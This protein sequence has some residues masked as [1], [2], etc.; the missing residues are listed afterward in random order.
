MPAPRTD[1]RSE[2]VSRVRVL[3]HE[4]RHDEA[5]RA[6]EGLPAKLRTD[7]ELLFLHALILERGER[8]ADAVPVAR[9]SLRAREH[10][11]TLLLLARC[12]RELGETEACLG[13]LDRVEAIRPGLESAAIVRG[14]ALE[15]AGR[16]DE[17]AAVLGPLVESYAGTGKRPPLALAVAWSRTLVQLKRFDE[18]IELIDEILSGRDLH[19]RVRALQL[20]LKA[21]AFDR[22]GN[23]EGAIAAATEANEIDRIDFQ[24]DLYTA[25]VDA[26]IANWSRESMATFP[27]SR[28]DSAVPVFIAGMPRS[29]TS[30]ID[31]I[32]DAHPRASG[33]GELDTIERFAVRL[34]AAY[35][36]ARP[37]G[38]RF[39]SFDSYRWT[40]AANDYV[41]EITAL[42]PPGTERVVN[43]SL[44]NNKL[45]GL[46]ARLF[47]NTRIIHAI[48]DPRDVAVSCFMG[49]FNNRLHAWT[50]RV[51]WVSHAWALS[52]RMME[53]WKEALDIP[54]LDVHYEN[55]VANP[56]R[57]FPRIIEF[58]GLE[59]DDRCLEF[60]ASRHTVRT[61]SYD[62]VNRP[63]YT[64]SSGRHRNYASLL[65]GTVFPAY[66]PAAS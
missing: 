48:R 41:K 65:D 25:Q 35:D 64:S 22:V 54:I 15:A 66:A 16:F 33:V 19:P 36:P 62:Q 6:I 26:L 58:L 63:L 4:Q 10:P 47:P 42:A 61:L 9:R 20:Y 12:Q 8:F 56:E 28:C 27:V 37:V 24:P 40:R 46:L 34:S 14:G 51:D 52:M 31:Q 7:P 29:G 21:K 11:D 23:F 55:L 2:G 5:L 13:T 38:K 1:K 45:V 53:H 30:L 18:G 59:W 50:T 60:H 44:G 17:A 3:L 32:I 43:K 39:G 57:E 49:G